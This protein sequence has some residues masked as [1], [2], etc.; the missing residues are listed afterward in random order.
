MNRREA[1]GALAG[2]I[3]LRPA[4][5]LAQD[6]DLDVVRGLLA[7]ERAA[8]RAYGQAA[9]LPHAGQLAAQDADHARVLATSVEAFGAQAPPGGHIP[10]DPLA[11]R[12]A[13]APTRRS[14]LRAA[15]ALEA[16]LIS[17]YGKALNMLVEPNTAMTVGRLAASHA[18][19]QVLLRQAA[20]RDPLAPR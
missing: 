3:L 14:A 9:A 6:P 1:L 11:A 18:Q 10:L 12:V 17:A 20:G 8:A 16:D 13:A 4:S 19:Q 15:L 5:A 2:A 7:R